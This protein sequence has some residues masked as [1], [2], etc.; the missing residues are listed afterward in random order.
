MRIAVWN[1]AW[2]GDSVLT[3][4]LIELVKNH[5]PNAAIDFYVRQG[6]GGLFTCHPAIARVFEFNKKQHTGPATLYRYGRGLAARKYSIWLSAHRSWR[7]SFIAQLAS[8]P[9]RIGYNSG[10]LS[11]LIYTHTVERDFYKLAE[12]ERILKLAV[13]LGIEL[14]LDT[15]LNMNAAPDKSSPA[16]WPHLALCPEAEAKADA[17]RQ[18][19]APDR[20]VLGI[21][22]GAAWPTKRWPVENVIAVARLA[23]AHQVQ[24]ILFGAPGEQVETDAVSAAMQDYPGFI[25]LAGQLSLPQL[26]ACLG[27]LDCFLSNDSGPMHLAWVQNTPVTAVFGPTVRALGFFPRGPHSTVIETK[28]SCRPCG[29]HGHR[30]CPK[31]HHACMRN[32]TPQQVW[33]DIARKLKLAGSTTTC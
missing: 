11:R 21:H 12:I 20:P 6:L 3:L 7:S 27:R 8:A 5:F 28:L 29:L 19:L 25:N 10:P 4:P 9:I 13:P 26:A 31:G 2:L 23:A 16:H 14:N 17:I 1:T 22:P 33:A 24:I 18:S 30:K 15:D 32:I